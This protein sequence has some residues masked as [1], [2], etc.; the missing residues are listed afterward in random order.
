M[1]F[2]PILTVRDLRVSFDTPSGEVRAVN[3]ISYDLRP[4]E[5]LGIVGESGS[6]KSV[7]AY[8]LLGLVPHPG[9]VTGGSVR[10]HGKEVLNAGERDLRKL[11]GGRIGMIFQNPMTSLNPVYPV[12]R[13][14]MEAYR[15]QRRA[16]RE[17]ARRRC[18]SMLEQVGLSCPEVRMGQYPHQLSGGMLQRVMIA[19]GLICDPE[20]L[21][22]DEPTTALDVTIQA[23][24]LEL[25]QKLQAKTGMAV[26]FITHNLG[27][28]AQ[29][30]HRV[31]VMYAGRFL[32]EG[33]TE[34]VLQCPGH[35]YTKG[36]LE[37]LPRLDG[38]EAGPLPFIPGAPPDPLTSPRG[39]PF[40]PRCPVCLPVCQ[41]RFPEWREASGR[42]AAC[43]Q[44]KGGAR[45]E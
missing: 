41:T 13:Q 22:A 42:R 23:Q 31:S 33:D 20:I 11:R 28:V 14:L 15:C 43:W 1:A 34:R 5:I 27:V 19:M 16:T 2:D 45:C 24:I 38:R 39:C 44:R 30:C 17:E 36:L 3:G 37:S 29:L 10:F 9:R 25:I 6:G 8:S 12:G 4:G 35:P 18:V 26:L 40:A 32:E 7:Q 21:I